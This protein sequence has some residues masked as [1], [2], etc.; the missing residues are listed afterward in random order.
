[1][2][3]PHE[4]NVNANKRAASPSRTLLWLII[5]ALIVGSALALLGRRPEPV[6]AG[7]PTRYFPF[8]TI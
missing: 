7:R 6:P 1:M 3:E 4:G 2:S 8:G 5:L